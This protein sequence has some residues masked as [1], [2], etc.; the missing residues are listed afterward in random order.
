[1]LSLLLLSYLVVLKSWLPH[2]Q[3]KSVASDLLLPLV[4]LLCS[5]A[6]RYMRFHRT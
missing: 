4:Y 2:F 5:A 3:F 6:A 1:M